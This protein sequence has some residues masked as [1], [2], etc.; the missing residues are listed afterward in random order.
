[1]RY[2]TGWL[3]AGVT[4][5]AI[6]APAVRADDPAKKKKG[7]YQAERAGWMLGMYM[8]E[9]KGHP[10]PFVVQLDPKSDAKAKGIRPGDELIRFQDEEVRQLARVFQDANKLRAG[11]EATLWIRR[12]SQTLQFRVR[13]PKDPG[14]TPEEAKEPEKKTGA[15]AADPKEAEKKKKKRRPVVIKPIPSDQPL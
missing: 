3:L 5:T 1:M 15:D 4:L 2:F 12:G 6:A 14:S 10:Y 11:R 8:G 9:E 13:V 7:V